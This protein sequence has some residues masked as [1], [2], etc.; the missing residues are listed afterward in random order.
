VHPGP[1]SYHAEDG[2]T[3][4]VSG[5]KVR[6][7]HR[8]SWTGAVQLRAGTAA[9]HRLSDDANRT[10]RRLVTYDEIP[11]NLV[12]AVLA[13]EDRRFFEHGGV[14]YIR[15]WAGDSQRSDAGTASIARAARR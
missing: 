6:I 7:D 1:Q 12:H 14:D 2:A 10:K 11:P 15:I 3:I 8:R 4:R 13:I 5:G 9:D